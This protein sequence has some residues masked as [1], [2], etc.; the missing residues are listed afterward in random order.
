MTPLGT[1]K[2]VDLIRWG[3]L[4]RPLDKINFRKKVDLIQMF[5]IRREFILKAKITFATF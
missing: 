4:S 5:K 2:K 3:T 1:K